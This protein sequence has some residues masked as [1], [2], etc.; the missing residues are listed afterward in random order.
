MQAFY[1][2]DPKHLCD[3]HFLNYFKKW[4]SQKYPTGVTNGTRDLNKCRPLRR[5]RTI[6]PVPISSVYA[7]INLSR[8]QDKQQA[9]MKDGQNGIID[10]IMSCVFLLHFNPLHSFASKREFGDACFVCH[11]TLKLNRVCAFRVVMMGA[12][13]VCLPYCTVV[14]TNTICHKHLQDQCI[15]VEVKILWNT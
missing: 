7:A 2:G 9:C 15:R 10:R 3:P 1:L 8:L 13:Q 14:R 5:P 4:R 6:N 12:G 11:V